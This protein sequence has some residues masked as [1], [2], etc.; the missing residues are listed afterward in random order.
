MTPVKLIFRSGRGLKTYHM[1]GW[2]WKH[3]EAHSVP[4]HQAD[5]L[6]KDFPDYFAKPVLVPQPAK[7]EDEK[8]GESKSEGKPT[9]NKSEAKPTYNR[10]S[11]RK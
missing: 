3:G 7:K 2:N 4:K 5:T 8:K 1:G 11:G 9:D 6:L 10:G